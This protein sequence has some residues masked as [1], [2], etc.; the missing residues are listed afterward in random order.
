ML[1]KWIKLHLFRWSLHLKQCPC[2]SYSSYWPWT[3]ELTLFWT[4]VS[5]TKVHGIPAEIQDLF[6]FCCYT[7]EGLSKYISQQNVHWVKTAWSWTFPLI[8]KQN[9]L[10]PFGGGGESENKAIIALGICYSLKNWGRHARWLFPMKDQR[11]QNEGYLLRNIPSSAFLLRT[12]VTCKAA[13]VPVF[14]ML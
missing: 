9:L 10:K 2:Q 7:E 8:G 11:H 14:T 13:V 4:N 6:C 12:L 1:F 5:N 3:V